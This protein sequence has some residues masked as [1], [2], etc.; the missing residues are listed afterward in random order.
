MTG[1]TGLIVVGCAAAVVVR[2][3]T[4][5]DTV[6]GLDAEATG[7]LVAI[8]SPWLTTASRAASVMGDLPVVLGLVLIL[9]VT[10]GMGS[11]SWRLLWVPLVAGGG[12]LIISAVIKLLIGR[13]R[14]ALSALVGAH[15]SAYPSGHAIRALAVY[16]ALAWLVAVAAR[17]RAVQILAGVC[18]GALIAAVG[19]SR[20]YLGVHW[21]IDVVAGHVLGAVWLAVV[22]ACLTPVGP[23]GRVP[24]TTRGVPGRTPRAPG[25][26]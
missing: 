18:A 12:A 10:A 13:A 23:T 25:L 8:R 4:P 6:T 26:P 5:D 7:Y 3:L 14:P 9:G 15:G 19:F 16:G 24:G 1:L 21:L 20:I 11:R 22:L 17:R 2:S